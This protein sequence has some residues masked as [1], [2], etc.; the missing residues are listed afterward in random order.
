MIVGPNQEEKHKLYIN[1]HIK[2]PGTNI[3]IFNIEA[4]GNIVL[5]LGDV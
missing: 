2:T 4:Y 1:I 5:P 3:E